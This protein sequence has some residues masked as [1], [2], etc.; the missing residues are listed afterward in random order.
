MP[1]HIPS[2]LLVLATSSALQAAVSA[3][4]PSPTPCVFAVPGILKQR[5]Q[6]H[7]QIRNLMKNKRYAEAEEKCLAASKLAPNDPFSQYMLVRVQ[8][9]QDKRDE[10]F[11][12]LKRAIRVGATNTDVF[13]AD[14]LLAP[15]RQDDRFQETLELAKSPDRDPASPW[16]WTVGP[17]EVAG[18]KVLVSE[19][20]TGWNSRLGVFMSLFRFPEEPASDEIIKGH[21]LIGTLLTRW[22]KEG[23]AAGNH[24]DVYDNYDA[25]HSSLRIRDFPQMTRL[26][27]DD[28][29][30]KRDFHRGLQTRFL[31][32]GVVLGNSSTAIT[33]GPFWRSLPR[34]AYTDSRSI[35]VLYA[36]YRSNMLYIYPEVRDHD[37]GHNGKGGGY[38]DVFPA[39]TPYVIISQGASGSDRPFLDAVACTLAAFRPE[40]KKS[41]REHGLLMPTIQ[42]ILRMSNK[43]VQT[44]QDYLKGSAHPTVFNGENLYPAKMVK[45]AHGIRL[46]EEPPMIQ[47]RV[48]EEDQP[49]VGRDYFHAGSDERLFTTPAAIARVVRSTKY[50]RRMVV[51]AETSVDVNERDLT[52]HWSVLRGNASKIKINPL[53]EQRSVVELLVPYHARRPMVPGSKLESNRVDIGAF[54]NNGKRYSAPG[55]ITFFSLDTEWRVY[56]ERNLIE[57]VRYQGRGEGNYVDP[58][59]DATKRWTDRY[60]YDEQGQLLGWTRVLDGNRQEFTPEGLLIIERGDDDR[61]IRVRAMRYELEQE[62][63]KPP[64]L[65]QRFGREGVRREKTDGGENHEIQR[66]HT[67]G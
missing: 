39:N 3:D 46:G 8:A 22:H 37:P 31:Y 25:G 62:P 32:S 58:S 54:V 47:L 19:E 34:L 51:S 50:L 24:E 55:F 1:R 17:A 49:I 18:G 67:I 10:A 11:A 53:N 48:V 14:P 66:K 15:L 29:V 45:M 41:L 65:R 64:I 20:N 36:Q 2:L 5:A 38:G 56:N 9:Q 60:A 35:A 26:Q 23:T 13:K 16:K 28:I 21:G 30:K 27:F 52:F 33:S 43:K 57:S 4:E 40:V 12:S 63:N 7:S 59:I 6:L 42:M 44:A 61:P